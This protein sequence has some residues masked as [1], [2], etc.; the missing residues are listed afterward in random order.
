VASGLALTLGLAAGAFTLTT[1]AASPAQAL[2]PRDD[3][4]CGP[5][6][7]PVDPADPTPPP[8]V[9]PVARFGW[10]V[11][12]LGGTVSTPSTASTGSLVLDACASN[13]GP[14]GTAAYQW[15]I[16]DVASGRTTSYSSTSCRTT[17]GGRPLNGHW[18]ADL[19][20]VANDGSVA[21]AS[22]D[23]PFRDSLVVQ[24]GDS[25]A[26]GEGNPT[27]ARPAAFDDNQCDRSSNA[28]AQ[29]AANRRRSQLGPHATLTLWNLACSG[30][31]IVT[32]PNG[33][34]GVL[35]PYGGQQPAYGPVLP[36]QVDQLRA[37]MSASGRQPDAVLVTAG[38]NDTGWADLVIQCYWMNKIGLGLVA[39][40]RELGYDV[41]A[42]L[43][44]VEPA[45]RQLSNRLHTQLPD[46]PDSRIYLT[47]Y[48]DATHDDRTA[49]TDPIAG[50]GYSWWC[51]RDAMAPAASSRKWGYRNVVVPLNAHIQRAA[52][53][54]GWHYVGGIMGDFRRHGLC[55]TNPWVVSPT[56]SRGRQGNFNGSW[57]ANL[58]GQQDIATRLLGSGA[59]DVSVRA[60]AF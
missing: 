58:A 45:F 53:E 60:P 22:H 1:F 32:A 33:H 18:T 10:R 38:A 11:P 14:S 29:L 30:A 41:Q 8:P 15:A 56:E 34:G 13:G 51:P 43:G 26:S 23:L 39:C 37:L 52:G 54:H 24:L 2:C 36:P 31:A 47:E 21:T 7:D 46:L 9:Q 50:P 4:D 48:W 40:E 42:R 19:R 35:R 25:A 27:H 44:L 49:T 20:V 17:V 3:T 12:S 5:D 28:A 6:I 59:F 55:A 57:H 16:H